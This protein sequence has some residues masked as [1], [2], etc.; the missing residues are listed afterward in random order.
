M[1]KKLTDPTTIEKLAILA[2]KKTGPNDSISDV[3]RKVIADYFE[4]KTAIEQHN[5]ALSAEKNAFKLL[6]EKKQEQKNKIKTKVKKQV[7]SG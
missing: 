6:Q 7:V 4:A 2:V 3:T 1:V 5:E